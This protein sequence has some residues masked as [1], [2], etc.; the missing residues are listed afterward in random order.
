MD[1]Y[2]HYRR[3]REYDDRPERERPARRRRRFDKYRVTGFLLMFFGVG[4]LAL[5]IFDV[6]W[7]VSRYG[8]NCFPD[9]MNVYQNCMG[10]H[11]YVYV[12]SALWG[13][14]MLIFAAFVALGLHPDKAHHER[15]HRHFLVL[16]G[17]DLV[18]MTPAIAVLNALE[19]YNGI[20]IF[21]MYDGN[22]NVTA[23]D[24]LQFGLPIT[25]CLLG[26]M[27]FFVILF[28]AIFMFCCNA[29]YRSYGYGRRYGSEGSEDSI[30]ERERERERPAPRDP[31]RHYYRGNPYQGG[32]G[33]RYYYN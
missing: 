18:L 25:I 5:G 1:Y 24:S 9:P 21:W 11:I 7:T 32:Y 31:Y 2:D 6:G 28:F 10:N 23:Y 17:I 16:L 13:G 22:G 8:N 3:S 15:A 20:N 19:V 14:A 29:D 26:G 12:G 27:A 30:R 4:I 33:K